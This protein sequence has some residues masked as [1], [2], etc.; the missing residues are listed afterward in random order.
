MISAGRRNPFG[1]PSPEVLERIGKSG[2]VAV[3]TS[4]LGSLRILTDGF[5]FELQHYS[6]CRKE[7]VTL[8]RGTADRD[9]ET[10]KSKQRSSKDPPNGDD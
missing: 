1:H 3:S 2:A 4:S 8:L 7:F 10:Q 6:L 9:A 5:R